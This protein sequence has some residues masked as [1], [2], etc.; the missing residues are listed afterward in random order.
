MISFY[1]LKFI[2]FQNSLYKYGGTATD[3]DV[4]FKKSL[5]DLGENFAALGNLDLVYCGIINLATD[6]VGR[7]VGAAIIE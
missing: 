4:I 5:D 3:I 7:D 6:T 2:I 1:K